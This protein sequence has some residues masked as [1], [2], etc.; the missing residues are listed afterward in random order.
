MDDKTRNKKKNNYPTTT[1]S[2][3]TMK[4]SSINIICVNAYLKRKQTNMSQFLNDYQ[5]QTKINVIE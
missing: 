4:M 2:L 3:G 1:Q 5:K